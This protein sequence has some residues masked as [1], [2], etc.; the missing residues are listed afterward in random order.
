MV[1]SG[2]LAPDN[3]RSVFKAYDVR[4]LVPQQVDEELARATGAAF[5]QVLGA[6]EIVVGHD[7]RPSSPDLVAAFADPGGCCSS[8][9]SGGESEPEGLHG[10]GQVLL[11]EVVVDGDGSG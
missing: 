9:G 11:D 6:S 1:D 2:T 5:V 4:G 3:V 8:E 10:Q 7:M